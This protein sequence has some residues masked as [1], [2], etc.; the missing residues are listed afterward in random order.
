ML[1]WADFHSKND[2]PK[3]YK[4]MADKKM[5][6]FQQVADAEYVYV[7]AADGSQVKIKKSDLFSSIF[8]YRGLASS[9]DFNDNDISG[10]YQTG[11]FSRNAAN[12]PGVGYGVLVC[13]DVGSYLL[14]FSFD[15]FE[16]KC[17]IE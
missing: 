8:Q 2:A 12:N 16:K 17:T 5:N 13:M 15:M 4:D 3:M 14:Q 9:N 6:E 11:D 7:E 10:S 1:N